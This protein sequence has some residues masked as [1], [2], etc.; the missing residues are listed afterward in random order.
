M[1]QPLLRSGRLNVNKRTPLSRW[2]SRTGSVIRLTLLGAQDGR[3]GHGGVGP[4][5]SIILRAASAPPRRR[6]TTV[7]AGP[8]LRRDR[9]AGSIAATVPRRGGYLP[10]S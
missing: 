6:A 7:G 1:F 10:I 8:G 5:F 4:S 9:G 3:R 2:R